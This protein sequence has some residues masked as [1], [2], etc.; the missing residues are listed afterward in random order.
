[1]R[2]NQFFGYVPEL[3]DRRDL[4]FT[5]FFAAVK[6]RPPLVDLRA[7]LSPV[8]NQGNLG[9]C[10]AQAIVGAAEHLWLK[11]GLKLQ[12]SRLW[13]YY[14]ERALHG[15][16][17]QD[18]GANIRDGIK[19]L[20]KSGL[21]EEKLWPYTISKFKTKPSASAD[22]QALLFKIDKYYKLTSLS[23]VKDA[24]VKGFTV[25]FGISLYESFWKHKK[26]LIPVPGSDENQEG[27][28]AMLIVGYDDTKKH[29]IIRNSWGSRWG[30]RGYCYIPYA[31][32]EEARDMW[33]FEIIDDGKE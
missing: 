22:K 3:T 4:L 14:K 1:M 30:D 27:G 6:K 2:K 15:W 12:G 26:G 29:F 17:N 7:G 16:Q 23:Q 20:A 28:H 13:L 10:T 18:T 33:C 11:Q 31:Y 5:D 21:P 19:V 32:M 9:S 24:L 25:A 8:E